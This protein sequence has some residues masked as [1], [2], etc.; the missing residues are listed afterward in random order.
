MKICHFIASSLFGGAEKVVLDLCNELSREHEVHLITFDIRENLYNL[1]PKVKCHT[2]NEFKRYNL[3]EIKKLLQLIHT[4]HPDIINTHSAKASR[5]VYTIKSFLPCA[6]VGTKHNARKGK[7]FNRLS[8]VIAVS[9]RVKESIKHTNVKIIHNGIKLE[10]IDTP[11]ENTIF[12][13]VAIG[14][15]DKIKGFDILIKECAKLNFE[16]HLQIIGEGKERDNLEKLIDALDVQNK[17]SLLGFRAD[18]PQVIAEA[19]VVVISSLSEGFSMIIVESL[20]YAKILI[21]RK[22]GISEEVLN[23]RL[24]IDDF[25][26]ADKIADVYNHEKKY[27]EIFQENTKAMKDHFLLENIALEYKNYYEEVLKK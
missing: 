23:T 24:L 1:S 15:L 16:F 14:R 10:K 20:M 5:I 7:I 26:I 6:F 13:I 25:K 27:K 9:R 11:K 8:N 21:S 19:N 2:L 17:V 12:T 18:T 4:I 3:F 22:V